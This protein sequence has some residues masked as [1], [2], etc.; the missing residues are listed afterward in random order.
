MERIGNHPA[1]QR[2]KGCI[3]TKA[4]NG[5]E[6][7]GAKHNRARMFLTWYQVNAR[8]PR[9]E[10]LLKKIRKIAQI[11][12][13]IRNSLWKLSGVNCGDSTEENNYVNKINGLSC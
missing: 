10:S 4:P 2:R 6:S 11:T 8:R 9:A 1:G 12:G 5:C 13:E 3:G 7:S